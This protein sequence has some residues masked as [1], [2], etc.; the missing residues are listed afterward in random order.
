MAKIREL[1]K[2]INYLTSELVS[3]CLTFQFFHAESSS[4]K[5]G[6]V[7]SKILENRN[8]L[9]Y[10][11]SHFAEAKNPRLVKK[12]FAEIRKDFDKSIEAL[13]NLVK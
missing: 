2:D 11:I 7:I 1:K 9:I 8:D 3:E 13:D 6:E 4:D 10:R 5:V 12:H